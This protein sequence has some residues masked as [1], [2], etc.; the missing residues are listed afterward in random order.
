MKNT[1]S[2]TGTKEN[3]WK[4]TGTEMTMNTKITKKINLTDTTIK[5]DITTERINTEVISQ[6]IVTDHPEI[7]GGKVRLNFDDNIAHHFF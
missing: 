7:V 6:N 5:I 2:M 3:Q 1:T 4:K